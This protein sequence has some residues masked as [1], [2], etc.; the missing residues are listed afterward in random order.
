MSTSKIIKLN[1]LIKIYPK[2]PL[3]SCLAYMFDGIA[4]SGIGLECR[5][6]YTCTVYLVRG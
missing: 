5:C 4:N 6:T 2:L 1:S 3:L